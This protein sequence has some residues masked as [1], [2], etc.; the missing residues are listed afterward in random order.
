[1][2]LKLSVLAQIQMGPLQAATTL[3]QIQ[4]KSVIIETLTK[5]QEENKF[6]TF[7]SAFILGL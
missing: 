6:P 7:A 4:M 1:M 3:T 5:S 2:R